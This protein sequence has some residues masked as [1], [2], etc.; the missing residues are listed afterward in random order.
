V[1]RRA[2]KFRI[3]GPSER[4]SLAPLTEGAGLGKGIGSRASTFLKALGAARLLF[5]ER[6]SG[7]GTFAGENALSE[8]PSDWGGDGYPYCV[9]G[10]SSDLR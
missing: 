3:T 1:S 10:S 9:A 2:G 5:G 4:S 7:A 6:F 8:F